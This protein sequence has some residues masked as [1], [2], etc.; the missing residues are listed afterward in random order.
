MAAE[1]LV[2]DKIEAVPKYANNQPILIIPNRRLQF[3]AKVIIKI[4]Y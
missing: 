4:T 1:Q 3:K 2:N